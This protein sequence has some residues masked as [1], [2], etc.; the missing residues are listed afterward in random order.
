MPSSLCALSCPPLPE[1]SILGEEPLGHPR[2][3]SQSA[4]WEVRSDP[5]R[6]AGVTKS[7]LPKLQVHNCTNS[8]I[9]QNDQNLSWETATL[10]ALSVQTA[11]SLLLAPPP[12]IMAGA[13][14]TGTHSPCRQPKPRLPAAAA[15]THKNVCVKFFFQHWMTALVSQSS[16]T[17]IPL[18]HYC[19]A[20]SVS[21]G[22]EALF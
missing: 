4:T 9:K 1:P 17:L 5:S 16:G 8:K 21:S 7:S 15:T 20:S 13:N 10:E 19:Q 6:G 12:D 3:K 18:M 2:H 14:L 22:I 11:R